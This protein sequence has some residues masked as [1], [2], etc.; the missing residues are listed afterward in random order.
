MQAQPT[1]YRHQI[2]NATPNLTPPVTPSL[3]TVEQLCQ[4]E[5]ALT[6]GGIRHLIFTKGHDLP[7]VYRFGRKIL[8]DRAEFIAGIK[9]GA[10]SK[11][12]GV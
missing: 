8:F 10:T 7:G 9:A 4:A 6:S 12:A 11:I 2:A 5:P 3:M 1:A